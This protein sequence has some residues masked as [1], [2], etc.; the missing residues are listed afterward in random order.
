MYAYLA[1]LELT[2]LLKHLLPVL[3]ATL[4]HI[5]LALACLLQQPALI[6]AQGPT[7]VVQGF[8]SVLSALLAHILI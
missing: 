7:V 2:H 1:L 3:I 8:Q 6:A 5:L 4:V